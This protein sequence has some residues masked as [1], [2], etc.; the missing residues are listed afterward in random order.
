MKTTHYLTNI[1]GAKIF[2]VFS[3]VLSLILFNYMYSQQIDNNV[4][5]IGIVYTAFVLLTTNILLTG[6][7]LLSLIEHKL[8][9]SINN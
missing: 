9:H 3:N 2:V 7:V 4:D 1:T 5:T 6:I 8:K